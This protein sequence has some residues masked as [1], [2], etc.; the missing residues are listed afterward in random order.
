MGEG[1]EQ[2]RMKE[3]SDRELAR[4]KT[5]TEIK[6]RER[7][8]NEDQRKQTEAYFTMRNKAKDAENSAYYMGKSVRSKWDHRHGW[9]GDRNVKVWKDE[10]GL[11]IDISSCTHLRDEML[12]L[13]SRPN[14]KL[15]ISKYHR[16]ELNERHGGNIRSLEPYAQTHDMKIFNK[17]PAKVQIL[18]GR[19][20]LESERYA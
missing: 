6:R 18:T 10:L 4:L 19:F 16:N 15:R 12:V 3:E 13:W 8:K 11:V 20:H 17:M 9:A 5:N 14:E 1:L 2:K 7:Q